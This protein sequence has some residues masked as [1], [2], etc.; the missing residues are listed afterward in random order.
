R[1]EAVDV[2]KHETHLEAM[3]IGSQEFVTQAPVEVAPVVELGEVV[4]RADAFESPRLVAKR[5]VRFREHSC[6]EGGKLV[7]ASQAGLEF[8][9]H[10]SQQHLAALP[11][12]LL[13]QV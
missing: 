3:T 6:R 9:E 12:E 4:S 5:S 1:L 8:D 7:V 13:G 10:D 2:E 11:V